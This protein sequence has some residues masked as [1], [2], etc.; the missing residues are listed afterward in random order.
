M[1]VVSATA[2]NLTVSARVSVDAATSLAAVKARFEKDLAAYLKSIAFEKSEVVYAR[3]GFLLLDIVGVTDYSDLL[4]NGKTQ[5]VT[6]GS[7][8]IPIASEVTLSAA[9]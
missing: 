1:T 5:N 8:Q 9:T 2:L 6:V 7:T 4:L 3:V